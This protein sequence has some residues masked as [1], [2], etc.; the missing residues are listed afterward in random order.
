VV[1]VGGAFQPAE[2]IVKRTRYMYCGRG[3]LVEVY[4]PSEAVFGS[5]SLGDGLPELGGRFCSRRRVF[6]YLINGIKKV[7]YYE[8]VSY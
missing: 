3:R 5:K 2:V 1:G 6:K 8:R 7:G 4:E